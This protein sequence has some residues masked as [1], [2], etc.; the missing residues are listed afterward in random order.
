MKRKLDTTPEQ[1][2]R[3]KTAKLNDLM[4]YKALS[5][6]DRVILYPT[7]YVDDMKRFLSHINTH[8]KEKRLEQADAFALPEMVRLILDCIDF[9]HI[10]STE[11]YRLKE[12]NSITYTEVPKR[13]LSIDWEWHTI[14][15]PNRFR[16]ISH[17][18]SL[19][20]NI[21]IF[22]KLLDGEITLNG[23]FSKL[24]S[25][26]ITL[27]YST[28]KKA[29][30]NCKDGCLISFI[31]KYSIP[32]N[33]KLTLVMPK[34]ASDYFYKTVYEA[35]GTNVY[36]VLGIKPESYFSTTGIFECT[37]NLMSHPRDEWYKLKTHTVLS[38]KTNINK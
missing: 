31:L 16:D 38:R 6:S 15:S 21:A 13:L 11:Y 32:D 28:A 4:L 26:C 12:I 24:K 36:D 14:P 35:Y 25:L 34:E 5:E 22:R 27:D 37:I 29:L 19:I 2:K 23:N 9:K 10:S 17:V 8:L 20:L 1:L 33:V 7:N 30:L 3:I 18:T